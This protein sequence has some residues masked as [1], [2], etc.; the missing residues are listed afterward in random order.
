MSPIPM[1]T[2]KMLAQQIRTT[3]LRGLA[4]PSTYVATCSLCDYRTTLP[5][6]LISTGTKRTQTKLSA[7]E[8]RCLQLKWSLLTSW[9]SRIVLH[10]PDPPSKR[11]CGRPRNS[12][13]NSIGDC[14]S[15]LTCSHSVA[16][17]AVNHLSLMT[18]PRFRQRHRRH[19]GVRCKG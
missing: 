3:L 6:S 9:R 2:K 10:V 8:L 12:E 11:R 7:G 15:R 19:S 4:L 5:S 14:Q 1:S 16:S 17:A 18:K 13:R